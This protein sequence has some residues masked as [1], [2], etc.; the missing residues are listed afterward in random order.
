M[1]IVAKLNCVEMLVKTRDGRLMIVDTRTPDR[2]V[3][4]EEDSPPE[5]TETDDTIVQFQPTPKWSN[6]LNYQLLL[7]EA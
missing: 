1:M 5:D 4:V 7:M 2:M 6:D 3:P